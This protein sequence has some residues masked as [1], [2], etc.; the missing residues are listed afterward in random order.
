MKDNQLDFNFP[1]VPSVTLIDPDGDELFTTSNEL[2]WL[3]IYSQLITKNLYKDYKV[4]YK[5][6][7]Y[8]FLPDDLLNGH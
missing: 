6:E 2:E 1:Q 8:E 4:K 7:I 3:H 5:G